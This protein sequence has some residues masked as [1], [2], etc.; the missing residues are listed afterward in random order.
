MGGAFVDSWSV[1]GSGRGF[2]CSTPSPTMKLDYWFADASGKAQPVWSNVVTS[3][4]TVSDHFPVLT[5]LHRA[6]VVRFG[7]P[8]WEAQARLPHYPGE[9]GS[10]AMVS[11]RSW[12]R[13]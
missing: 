12:N 13:C 5:L 6:A 4:G 10:L 7:D 11:A 8:R 3:T 2:T 1:V 9:N